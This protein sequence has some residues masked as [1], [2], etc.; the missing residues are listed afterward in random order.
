MVHRTEYETKSTD[1]IE[2]KRL[3]NYSQLARSTREWDCQTVGY[4]SVL[5]S[6]DGLYLLYSGNDNGAGG[7]GIAGQE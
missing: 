3:D 1:G 2:W 6:S 4:P 7:F 5:E